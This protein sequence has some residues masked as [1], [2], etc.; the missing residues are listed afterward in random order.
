MTIEITTLNGFQICLD[1]RPAPSLTN[2]E[3]A[4]LVIL[5]WT[6]GTITTR[7]W[8][9]EVL[10]D[11]STTRSRRHSLSQLLYR[12]S[13]KLPIKFRSTTST[14]A[15][16]PE[17]FWCDAKAFISHAE[18]GESEPAIRLFRRPFLQDG[19]N[20]PSRAFEE[21]CDGVKQSIERHAVRILMLAVT[22]SQLHDSARDC[23]T[24]VRG[25]AFGT[26]HG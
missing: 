14:I 12:L 9:I 15:V 13:S 17:T 1:G 10:W 23:A 6:A 2:T 11:Q 26:G 18:A 22:S 5:A 19:I 21:W 16:D 8:L 25:V 4:L 24:K 20:A 3:R 7:Q